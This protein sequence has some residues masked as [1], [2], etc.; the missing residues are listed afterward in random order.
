MA[1]KTRFLKTQILLL[2]AFPS[3]VYAE[4]RRMD[5]AMMTALCTLMQMASG[6]LLV[7]AAGFFIISFKDKNPDMKSNSMKLF[8]AFLVCLLMLPLMRAAGFAY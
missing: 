4:E 6:L 5:K 8:G 7:L 3:I 2:S 1:N